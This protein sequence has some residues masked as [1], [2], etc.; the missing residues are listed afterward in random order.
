MPVFITIMLV[1]FIPHI[2]HGGI[3][4]PLLRP[5]LAALSLSLRLDDDC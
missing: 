1:I 5:R 2:F 4:F 3:S